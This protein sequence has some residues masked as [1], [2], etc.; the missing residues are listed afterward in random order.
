MRRPSDRRQ[1]RNAEHRIAARGRGELRDKPQRNPQPANDHGPNGAHSPP[2]DTL[3]V[4]SQG[5]TTPSPRTGRCHI[6]CSANR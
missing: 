4:K 5:S 3:R 6:G 2:P 1:L